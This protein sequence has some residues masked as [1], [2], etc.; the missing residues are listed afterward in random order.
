MLWDPACFSFNTHQGLT[1]KH[2]LGKGNC[3]SL[4]RAEGLRR[5][6]QRGQEMGR[7]AVRAWAE[8][9][10]GG[11][12]SRTSCVRPRALLTCRMQPLLRHQER[13]QIPD[14]TAVSL[15]C[16]LCAGSIPPQ[17]PCVTS[18]PPLPPAPAAPSCPHPPLPAPSVRLIIHDQLKYI[19]KRASL[20]L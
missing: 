19:F 14:G 1:A 2:S 20:L 15:T 18:P 16:C 8:G 7:E 4:R 3:S 6:S 9:G 13:G 12:G 11:G 17:H 5:A 10:G